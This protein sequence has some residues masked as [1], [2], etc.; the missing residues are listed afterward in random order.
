MPQT[1]DRALDRRV[2]GHHDHGQGAAGRMRGQVLQHV[3]PAA[4]RQIQVDQH[5][6]GNEARQCRPGLGDGG[7]GVD[8][9]AV[10]GEDGGQA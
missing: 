9:E 10:G 8:G 3:E 7:R 1:L 4:V 6:I 5:D 2:T